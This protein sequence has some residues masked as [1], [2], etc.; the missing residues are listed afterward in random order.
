M[1]TIIRDERDL[2]MATGT[3]RP[4]AAVHPS[5]SNTSQADSQQT[6]PRTADQDPVAVLQ[7][8]LDH[9]RSAECT[10]SNSAAAASLNLC[11]E[12]S[13]H[14]RSILGSSNTQLVNACDS[15]CTTTSDSDSSHY[16]GSSKARPNS[17][18]RA[19]WRRH[20]Q[21]QDEAAAEADAAAEAAAWHHMQ[22][23]QWQWQWGE[24]MKR[25]TA[26]P[27]PGAI[28]QRMQE[29][30]F[31]SSLWTGEW[32]LAPPMS[33]QQADAAQLDESRFRQAMWNG[34]W[35]MIQANRPRQAQALAQVS[36]EP[37]CTPTKSPA[38]ASSAAPAAD[39]AAADG[40]NSFR[41]RVQR[42]MKKWRWQHMQ[43]VWTE[44]MREHDGLV[45][46]Q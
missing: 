7:S 34:N 17:R 24:H 22:W 12:M 20:K 43:E 32:Q 3:A 11:E 39:A 45:D 16:T 15:Q 31:R 18:T 1:C 30:Q 41:K 27:P 29:Q 19:R 28:E 14:L 42:C 38:S 2:N 35:Q 13:Q 40:Q 9:M 6:R 37:T 10:L 8:L 4:S 46:A 26:M 21:E 25:R 33:P 5:A 23:Q 36:E 44:W